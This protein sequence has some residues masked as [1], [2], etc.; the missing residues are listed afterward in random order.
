M[1]NVFIK[2]KIYI[3]RSILLKTSN[4]KH[5]LSIYLVSKLTKVLQ[6]PNA[7]VKSSPAFGMFTSPLIQERL[8]S[9]G[10][11]DTV[12]S[13]LFFFL[14]FPQFWNSTPPFRCWYAQVSN[15]SSV[16]FLFY[17]SL[18]S[19]LFLRYKCSQFEMAWMVTNLNSQSE[20][21]FWSANPYAI[22]I[23]MQPFWQQVHLSSCLPIPLPISLFTCPFFCV[24]Y[25]S[26]WVIIQQ[27]AQARN[28][29]SILKS[30][31]IFI[32]CTWL[33]ILPQNISFIFSFL[34]STN[35]LF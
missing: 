28:L 32:D 19:V 20:S 34:F 26:Y 23:E 4:L 11:H 8:F 25:F 15:L 27:V 7:E 2:K 16:P 12:S 33:L 3:F 22:R 35:V 10:F 31:Y 24:S 14:Y 1:I 17:K 9:L 29:R 6:N 18:S 5:L 21:L 30:F 13:T